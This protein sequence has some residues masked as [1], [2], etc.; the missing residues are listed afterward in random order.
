MAILVIF[1]NGKPDSK[2]GLKAIAA[3]GNFIVTET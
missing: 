2:L 3:I 1:I